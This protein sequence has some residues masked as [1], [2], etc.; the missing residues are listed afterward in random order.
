LAGEKQGNGV[1]TGIQGPGA[2][3]GEV[4]PKKAKSYAAKKG[5]PVGVDRGIDKFAASIEKRR[6]SGKSQRE[7][8]FSSSWRLQK[9]SA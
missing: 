8:G 3:I 6:P 9:R 1:G 4:H 2:L 7:P 5:L